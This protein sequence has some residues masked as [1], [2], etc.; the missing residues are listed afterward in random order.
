MPDVSVVTITYNEA[1]NIGPLLDAIRGAFDAGRLDGEVIVVDDDSPD[2][3]AAIV[4]RYA[5]RHPAVRLV[6]R[7]GERGI[8]SAFRRG[9]DEAR[10]EVIVTMDAD[11]SHPPDRIPALVAVARGGAV[12]SGSR[13][14]Q[15]GVFTTSWYRLVGTKTLNVWLYFFLRLGIWDH[16]NG[17][18]AARAEDLRRIRAAAASVG[19]DPF[20]RILYGYTVFAFARRLGMPVVEVPAPYVFRTRGETKIRFWRGVRLL[21]EEIAYSFRLRREVRRYVT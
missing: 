3:T 6:V 9:V 19:I 13:L 5:E 1:E 4:A 20:E 16:T 8:G 14:L 17:Y 21:V 2:G 12:V 15:G 18:M 10:G 11:F 7:K